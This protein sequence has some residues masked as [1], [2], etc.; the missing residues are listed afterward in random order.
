QEIVDEA[1]R[2]DSPIQMQT[3]VLDPQQLQ[4]KMVTVVSQSRFALD[5]GMQPQHQ[6]TSTVVPASTPPVF[7]KP[8]EQKVAQIT[9]EVIKTFENQPQRVP[10]LAHLAKP[11][12]QAEI[13]RAVEERYAPA[14]MGLEG[15]A[16]KP[17][18][19]AIVAKTSER[20]A[21]GMIDI[22]RILIVPKGELKSGFKSFKLNLVNLN[23]QPV[24]DELWAQ[25][26]RDGKAE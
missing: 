2:P 7:T 14:Q 3:V 1:R 13:V 20:A 6:T 24:S 21:L 9:Y 18:I 22:P 15:V 5:L 26:L 16:E 12:I 4:T 23:Y 8:E 19:A 11:E 10:T 17:D 25:N